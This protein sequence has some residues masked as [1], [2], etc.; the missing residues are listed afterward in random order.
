MAIF[1]QF[2]LLGLGPAGIYALAGQG[3]VLIYRG[4]GVLNFAYGAQ[5]LVAAEVFVWLWQDKTWPLT[6]AIV[7]S[8][9]MSA[10]GLSSKAA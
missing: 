10:A 7:T 1:L 2:V 8:V 5:A 9:V 4:S 6:A 3:L